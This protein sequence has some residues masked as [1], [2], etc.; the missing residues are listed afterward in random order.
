MRIGLHKKYIQRRKE[1]EAKEL[2]ERIERETKSGIILYPQPNDVLIGKGRPYQNYPGNRRYG[3][4]IDSNLDL[5]HKEIDRFAKM[6][7]TMDIVKQVQAYQEKYRSLKPQANRTIN[8]ARSKESEA[9][10]I[11]R[12]LPSRRRC[13]RMDLMANILLS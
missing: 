12:S 5:Y 1:I 7:L 10:V 11:R 3:A 4:M 8:R 2:K 9:N 13:I 6:C